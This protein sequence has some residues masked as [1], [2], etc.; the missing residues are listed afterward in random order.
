MP[1]TEEQLEEIYPEPDGYIAVK[2]RR[3]NGSDCYFGPFTTMDELLGWAD[4]VGLQVAI[5]PLYK[6]VDWRR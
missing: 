4:T 1:W 5:I 3:P 6:T 2:Y